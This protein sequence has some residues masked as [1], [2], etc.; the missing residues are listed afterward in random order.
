[1]STTDCARYLVADQHW[2]CN[3]AYLIVG[4]VIIL[5]F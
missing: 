2:Q 3:Y 4:V 1:M 5:P